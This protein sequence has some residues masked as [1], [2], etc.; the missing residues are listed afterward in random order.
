MFTPGASASLRSASV[1]MRSGTPTLVPPRKAAN[2][3]SDGSR[4]HGSAF[5]RG[6]LCHHHIP[7]GLHRSGEDDP[8]HCSG[9]QSP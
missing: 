2:S 5:H 9:L 6:I 4:H 8:G 1:A 3:Q 7:K